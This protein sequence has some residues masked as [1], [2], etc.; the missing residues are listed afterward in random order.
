MVLLKGSTMAEVLYHI[1]GRHIGPD[2]LDDIRATVSNRWASGRSA[3]SRHLCE[4]WNWRQPNGQL[5]DMACRALLLSLEAKGVVTLPP[6]LT[7]SFRAPRRAD[8]QS[9]SVDDSP[10]EGV[11]NQFG[12]LT[13]RMV[14]QTPDE[15]LWDYLVDTHHYLSRPWIV[16]SNLKYLA[17]LDGRLV[18]C[19]GWGSAAWKVACRDVLIGWDTSVRSNNL[20]Q[21]VNNVRFLILPWVKVRH[22]ASKVLAMNLRVLASDWQTF[23][24]HDICL[25]ETF[26]DTERFKGTCYQAANWHCVGMTKGRGRYDRDHHATAS[27][28]AVYLYPLA[29]N[30]RERLHG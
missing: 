13:I 30:Y 27:I 8:R 25:A 23:Y 26:V 22:L 1:R 16:G 9:F 24:A 20:H 29:R 11:V 2:D 10:V 6:R 7:E 17:Y 21:V 4:Q 5:K 3:I 12:S 28:K 15:S 18:A 14:R 19:L